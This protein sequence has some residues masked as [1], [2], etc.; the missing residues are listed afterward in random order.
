MINEYLIIR[1]TV[2]PALTKHVLIK[3]FCIASIGI[4]GLLA[5]GIFLP[6]SILHQWGWA[7]FFISIGFITLG[8]LPYRRL[9]RLQMKP[10]EL[11]IFDADQMTFISR[12]S[13]KLTVPLQSISKMAYIDHPLNYGIALW[14]K[15]PTPIPVIVHESPK[16]AEK[17]RKKG[18]EIENA[19]LFFSHFNRHAYDELIG[20]IAEES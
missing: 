4:F 6:P 9:V 11:S 12:G 2:M 7:I 15:H 5:G 19:D 16:Q 3:G 1:T 13:K 10:N 17:M 8:L 20:W 18:K 14:L